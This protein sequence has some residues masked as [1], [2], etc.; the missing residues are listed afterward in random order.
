MYNACHT[1]RVTA[2][3]VKEENTG[4][5]DNGGGHRLQNSFL[6]SMV[7]TRPVE[8][9]GRVLGGGCGWRGCGLHGCAECVAVPVDGERES[10]DTLHADEVS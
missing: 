8:W 4:A 7:R 1:R 10:A 9:L 3:M 2:G 6:R 5:S